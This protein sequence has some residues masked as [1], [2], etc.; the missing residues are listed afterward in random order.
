MVDWVGEGELRQVRRGGALQRLADRT[1]R[2]RK[3]K[4]ALHR[5]AADAEVPELGERGVPP[6]VTVL[7]ERR[8]AVAEELRVVA[9]ELCFGDIERVA[10]GRE[11]ILHDDDGI[12]A[13]ALL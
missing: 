9:V 13:A 5:E 3:V 8:E 2:D 7:A 1:G 4:V 6:L 12:H 11:E 10:A